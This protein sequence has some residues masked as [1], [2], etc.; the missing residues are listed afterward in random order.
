MSLLRSVSAAPK[1]TVGDARL[2]TERHRI[3]GHTVFE[4]T[5]QVPLAHGFTDAAPAAGAT[6]ASDA[7]PVSGPNS[8]LSAAPAS[9][10]NP[11]TSATLASVRTGPPA[12]LPTTIEVFAREF[13]RDGNEDAPRMLFLQGGPGMRATRFDTVHGWLDRA[14]EDFRVVLLDQRGTG[15]STPLDALTLNALGE[16][17][18][19]AAYL[20]H[21]RADAIVAD[22]EALRLA[23]GSGRWTTL[24]QSYGGFL[25]CTYLSFAPQG[26]A[27]SIITAGLPSLT[28]P[29]EDV[30]RLTFEYTARRYAEFADRFPHDAGVIARVLRH[31]RETEETLP[32]GERLT[33]QRFLMIG[34]DLGRSTGFASLHH[35][36]EDPFATVSGRARLRPWFLAEVAQQ[37]SFAQHPLYALMHE[38]IY[39]QGTLSGATNWAAQRVRDRLPAFDARSDTCIPTAEHLGPWLFDEDPALKPLRETAEI[40]AKREDFPALYR[41]DVLA[42]NHVPVAAAIWT[43]DVFVPHELS[44]ETARTINGLRPWITNE[45]HHNALRAD[46]YRVLDRLLAL[47]RG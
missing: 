25:T 37:V 23:L 36:L 11:A 38:T 29:A 16:P 33:P 8:G 22:A 1:F 45:Y 31:L 10:T 14:L 30:Y 4:H 35:L 27:S 32:T 34:M 39:A 43:D 44:M 20:A 2:T 3:D 41:P 17:A 9:G 24:G 18:T 5:M 40:L 15:A 46:G 26:L 7:N 21:H 6:R 19:Q 47:L 12:P 13:V 42:H 28:R